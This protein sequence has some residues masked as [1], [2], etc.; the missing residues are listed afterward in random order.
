MTQNA[1]KID[2]YNKIIEFAGRKKRVGTLFSDDFSSVM[3]KKVQQHFQ[4]I[5]N[6]YTQ[7]RPY[8][9]TLFDE[10]M[11]GKLKESEYACT[12]NRANIKT[13]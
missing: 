10:C 11:K 12:D 4:E 5:P 3:K 8:V 6:V 9:E 13:K 2:S 7:Y 1:S